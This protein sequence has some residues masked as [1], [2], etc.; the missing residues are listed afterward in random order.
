MYLI[1][2]LK[3]VEFSV[4]NGD[5]RQDLHTWASNMKAVPLYKKIGLQWVPKT[6]VYMQN[7]MPGI[8]QNNFC[9]AFFQK[10]P[11]WYLNHK[12]ELTQA[13]DEVKLNNMDVFLYRFETEEADFLEVTIDRYSR[14]ISGITRNLD[15]EMISLSLQQTQHEIHAG[16][17][18]NLSLEVQNN[19]KNDLKL[20]VSMNPSKEIDM[21]FTQEVFTI[22]RGR[23]SIDCSYKAHSTT[24]DS[25]DSRKSPSIKSD[26]IVNS[27]FLSLE[28]GMKTQQII[29]IYSPSLTLW[30]P[31][32]HQEIPI[33]IQNRSKESVEGKLVVWTEQ[34]IE[35]LTNQ[36]SISLTPEQNMGLKVPVK[37]DNSTLSAFII[38]NC[39]LN[40]NGL[41]SRIFQIPF[42]TSRYPSVTGG[43]LK[44]KK[45]IILHNQYIKTIINLEGASVLIYSEDPTQIGLGLGDFDYGP[46]FG[47][48]EFS[49]VEFGYKFIQEKN[50]VRATLSQTSR[51]Q[52]HLIFK[53]IFE[54][55]SGETH[56]AIWEEIENRSTRSVTTTTISAPYF[57][58]GINM[59][60]GVTHLVL[61]GEL[62]SGPC[63]TWPANEG[64]LPK[65]TERYEPWIA[66]QS[67]NVVHYHIFDPINTLADPSKSRLMTLEKTLELSPLKITKG[68][69]SWL[70]IRIGGNYNYV[71][72][73]AYKLT[74]NQVME[75]SD[76]IKK[77]NPVLNISIPQKELIIDQQVKQL[78]FSVRSS[79]NLP[80]SGKIEFKT[81]NRIQ[82][83][84]NVFDIDNLHLNEQKTLNVEIRISKEFPAGLYPL[85]AIFHS[86]FTIKEF[87]FNLLIL[88]STRDPLIH[89]LPITEGN[90]LWSVEN[91]FLT[92]HSSPDYAA[93]LVAIKEGENKHLLSN[94]PAFQPS[95][96]SNKDPGGIHTII[97]GNND[98]LND[99]DYLKDEYEPAIVK[100]EPWYGIEYSSIFHHRKS[101]KG[102]KVT[103]AYELLKGKSNIIRAR[104]TLTNP[105]TAIFNFSSFTLLK[106]GLNDSIE[107]LLCKF[108]HSDNETTLLSRENP[109]PVIGLGSDNMKTIL[110]ENEKKKF[111]LIKGKNGGKLFPIALGHQLLGGGVFS[112]WLLNP[113]EIKEISFY[114]VINGNEEYIR[115]ISEFVSKL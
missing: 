28:V 111:S 43:V 55:R 104:I 14:A 25:K 9:K 93:S 77:P 47:F 10:H 33:N 39:Q 13:P 56:I 5:L 45:Q 98:D 27:E 34:N 99:T 2:L 110:F 84:P 42:T 64:D 53:R 35:I 112:Y 85:T 107:K 62:I 89:E 87:T 101:L 41:R 11:N 94:F 100:S 105:T 40:I 113:G 106:Y 20:V 7:F 60:L 18:Q 23:Q 58:R 57:S 31:P 15:G 75:S 76:N 38:L 69:L 17:K 19:T 26:I 82:M 74:K 51:S 90:R 61:D 97:L 73:E 24:P 32:G 81:D 91:D 79:R 67:G 36:F 88:N 95:L 70:G 16:I 21:V 96:L 22:P 72:E 115:N 66:I 63:F 59:P 29:D 103:Y 52:P 3:A 6:S 109:M 48:S 1:L 4:K 86:P 114:I 8:L 78:D 102:L 54:L 12:R 46:P 92:L 44:D 108:K 83:T 50:L 80:L 71:R 68:P 49:Q 37:I 30:F 65:R